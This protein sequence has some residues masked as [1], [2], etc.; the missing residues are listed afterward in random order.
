MHV[1]R[2]LILNLLSLKLIGLYESE[3]DSDNSEIS[4]GTEQNNSED[5]TVV[6]DNSV[7]MEVQDVNNHESST[8]YQKRMEISAG[9]HYSL[10]KS[11]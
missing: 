4:T 9:P 6:I 1:L 10:L 3:T 11:I 8:S 2:N 5:G 7:E